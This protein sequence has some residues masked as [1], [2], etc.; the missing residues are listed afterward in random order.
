MP[1]VPRGDSHGRH[2]SSHG[3]DHS[4]A[5]VRGTHHHAKSISNPKLG[6]TPNEGGSAT[7]AGPGDNDADD[8]ME[9]GMPPGG[10]SAGG[11]GGAGGAP[12]M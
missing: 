2:A 6:L 11:M 1:R 5:H 4:G 8:L 3:S 7:P 10:G 9:G 12:A